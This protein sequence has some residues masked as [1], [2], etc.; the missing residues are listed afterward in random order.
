MVDFTVVVDLT[1]KTETASQNGTSD[2]MDLLRQLNNEK[3][4]LLIPAIVYTVVL[5]VVGVVGNPLAIYIYGFRWEKTTLKYFLLSLAVLD[6]V[7]CVITM[8]TEIAMLLNFYY[9]PNAEICKFSRFTTYV[10]NNASSVIFLVIAVDRYI[11]ICKPYRSSIS[12]RASKITCCLALVAGVCVS[13]PA[14]VMYD[15]NDVRITADVTGAV[16]G[17]DSSKYKPYLFAFFI[18]LWVACGLI[19][20]VLS[21]LYILI[22]KAIVIRKMKKQSWSSVSEKSSKRSDAEKASHNERCSMTSPKHVT[23]D[24]N[25]MEHATLKDC[26][27]VL[28]N[29]NRGHKRESKL[30]KGLSKFHPGRST[31]MLFAITVVYV[32]T[33]LPFL[34]ITI[35]RTH[36]GESFY[37]SLSKQEEIAVNIFLRSYLVNNCANPIVYGLFNAQFRRECKELFTRVCCRNTSNDNTSHL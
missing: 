5:M 14:I 35:I 23:S 7:N 18:Y 2:G 9:F 27:C 24:N 13:W 26:S 28:S 32:V 36:V 6:L 34:V 10:M 12:V 21:V 30:R 25:A 3:A 33:F 19:G 11:K 20:V 16:C 4:I 37:P 1:N 31:M 17:V 29:E 22:W 8:P 15:R